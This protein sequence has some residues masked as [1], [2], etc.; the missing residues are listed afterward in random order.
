MDSLAP[1]Y[2]D[3]RPPRFL[4]LKFPSL[5]NKTSPVKKKSKAFHIRKIRRH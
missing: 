3:H 5:E 1:D 4:Q 2:N